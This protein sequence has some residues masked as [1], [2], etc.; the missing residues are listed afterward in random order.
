M[1]TT[2]PEKLYTLSE[3][4]E[5]LSISTA[6]GRNWMKS[7]RLIPV[8]HD[9]KSKPLFQK[10]HLFSL[11]E[12][13]S[14]G[15]IPGLKSR[16]N[17]TYI[18]TETP[19][20]ND[21]SIRCQLRCCAEQLILSAGYKDVF[22]FQVFLND[23]AEENCFCNW[24][25]E[26]PAYCTE[27]VYTYASD[28]DTLGL[29]YQS[30]RHMGD[31]KVSG[32]YYTSAS[33][34]KRLLEHHL[35]VLQ[36]NHTVFDPSCGTGIFLL[37]LPKDVPLKNIYGNDINP[38]SVTLT[39][40][41]LALKYHI[42][43]LQEVE[44]LQKNI[45]VS[46][47]LADHTGSYDIIVGNPPWGAKLSSEEKKTYR[48]RFSCAQGNSIEIYDLFIEQSLKKLSSNGILAFV[49]PE[50]ILTVKSHT[51]VRELLLKNTRV[52]SVE[53]LGEAFEQVH[54]PSIIFAV[55]KNTYCP[56]F[57]NVPVTLPNG[58]IISTKV[59]HII[60]ADFF[61]FGITDEEY[62]LLS[63]ITSCPS[64]TTLVEQSEFALGIVT[65]NNAALLHDSPASGLEPVIKGS[66]ISKYHIN[67]Y[68]G[69]V[70]FRPEHFQQ[71]AP[72]HLY[73]AP[74]KLFYRFIN[75]KL[76]F[77]YD[78]T[79]L[80]SLNSCNIVI[81]QIPGLSV[82][83]VLAVLNSSV[84]QFFFEKKFHS[85]KVLRSHLEQVPI[86]MADKETQNEVVELVDKLMVLDETTQEFKENYKCL[87]RKV[88]E[89][90]SLTQNEFEIICN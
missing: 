9:A 19:A 60:H 64:L 78:N 36:S 86:P 8:A 32:S 54:C 62:L 26:N 42:T 71:T 53:Y 2:Y 45:T 51:P 33:L 35:P 87:D 57:K 74:E 48:S 68:S 79:G 83:Y 41:N 21:I 40:I 13:L 3:A 67:S 38:L 22:L 7:G 73:R 44:L 89:L 90:F 58:A 39:R 81:P 88:A 34:A 37:Q 16:R 65:G 5:L 1:S 49:L 43:T 11:K 20:L 10:D 14:N 15:T 46:D 80:L 55:E 84:A 4:C 70:T 56:F 82:K 6:T 25:T 63:N 23:L 47:F 50:A 66:D 28:K 72:E 27:T 18:S 17:K 59:E 75:K 85:V 24:K 12:A 52:R 29:L 76:I 69:Y 31:R 61:N 77:A 30:L